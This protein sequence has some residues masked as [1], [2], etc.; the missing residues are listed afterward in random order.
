MPRKRYVKIRRVGRT[1]IRRVRRGGKQVWSWKSIIAGTIGLLAMKK[2]IGENSLLNISLGAYDPAVQKI[3]AG[4]VLSQVGLD[5]SDLISAGA[6]E[7]VATLADNLISGKGLG[8]GAT[9]TGNYL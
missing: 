8:G 9:A 1:V 6:K 2:V 5:N 3:T 7:A 4:F